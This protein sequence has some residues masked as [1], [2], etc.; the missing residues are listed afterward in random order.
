M[1]ISVPTWSHSFGDTNYRH[2]LVQHLRSTERAW[3]LSP[4]A[5][6]PGLVALVDAASRLD[7]RLVTR[8]NEE[9]VLAGMVDLD[10]LAD[11]V[12]AGGR[13]RFYDKS[14]H[15]KL[16]LFSEVAFVG[17]VNLTGQAL[18]DNAEAMAALVTALAEPSL[19][20]SYTAIWEV[21]SIGV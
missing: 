9:D 3:F 16:W 12:E 19:V 6:R 5:T 18:S 13:V 7:V 20:N 2:L 14:L 15:A 1:E 4:F 21:T 8:F 10:A 11:L 17:S